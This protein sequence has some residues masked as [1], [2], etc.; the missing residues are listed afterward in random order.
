MTKRRSRELRILDP[1]LECLRDCDAACC[2]R[3]TNIPLNGRELAHNR[4]SMQVDVIQK[5]ES[6]D[7]TIPPLSPK[8][9]PQL[10][11]AHVG[12][13]QL[14][15]DCGHLVVGGNECRVYDQVSPVRPNA[16]PSMIPGSLACLAVRAKAGY[17]DVLS[18]STA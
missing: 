13:Y 5:P 11:P 2:R 4:L 18:E 6:Q 3:N 1:A 12:I 9:N 10:I 17:E 7:R 15:R 14:K 8:E 16:C